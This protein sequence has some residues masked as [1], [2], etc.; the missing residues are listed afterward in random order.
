MSGGHGGLHRV[1]SATRAIPSFPPPPP[2]DVW[3]GCLHASLDAF[4]C[5]RLYFFVSIASLD[6][7]VGFCAVLDG[8]CILHDVAVFFCFGTFRHHCRFRDGRA[9]ESTAQACV[10]LMVHITTTRGHV[11][12]PPLPHTPHQSRPP[13]HTRLPTSP[14]SSHF[15]PRSMAAASLPVHRRPASVRARAWATPHWPMQGASNAGS[16]ATG[17]GLTPNENWHSYVS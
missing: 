4:V 5:F 11:P 8:K 15:L 2:G 9:V 16:S 14:P 6:D 1:E 7:G 17:G 12:S 3:R 13:S 10:Q